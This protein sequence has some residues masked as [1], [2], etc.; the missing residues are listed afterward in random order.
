MRL[1][2][3]QASELALLIFAGQFDNPNPVFPKGVEVLA[4]TEIIQKL[5]YGKQFDLEVQQNDL[6]TASVKA[7]GETGI[8]TTQHFQLSSALVNLARKLL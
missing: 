3:E 2:Q 6:G 7:F 1:N 4:A 5:S 8:S